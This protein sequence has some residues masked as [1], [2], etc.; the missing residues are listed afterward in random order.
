VATS[1]AAGTGPPSVCIGGR[2][3]HT[4]L[5]LRACLALERKAAFRN[6]WWL[7]DEGPPQA[8]LTFRARIAYFLP[9]NG[10]HFVIN[11]L[12]VEPQRAPYL[13]RFPSVVICCTQVGPTN[14]Q[15]GNK[16]G[17]STFIAF[18]QRMQKARFLSNTQVTQGKTLLSVHRECRKLGS[19]PTH[20]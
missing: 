18:S 19:S 20:K 11:K 17:S 16:T 12:R 5:V 6:P 4:V 15:I 13:A 9:V 3:K 14:Q 1:S 7:R 10:A 8:L 2:G